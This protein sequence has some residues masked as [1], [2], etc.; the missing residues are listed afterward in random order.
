VTGEAFT[1]LFRSMLWG[2][3]V[4]A[5]LLA[6]ASGALS[7]LAFTDRNAG[8]GGVVLFFSA[9]ICLIALF[10]AWAFA[11]YAR[12]RPGGA[13]SPVESAGPG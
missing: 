5:T 3:A 2:A 10:S 6:I 9:P 8:W 4:F 11:W 7:Y 12:Y 1:P 13:A